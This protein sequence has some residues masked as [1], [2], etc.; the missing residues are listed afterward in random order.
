MLEPYIGVQSQVNRESRK[1]LTMQPC[2]MPVLRVKVEEERLSSLTEWGLFVRMSRVQLQSVVLISSWLSFEIS[3]ECIKMLT[4]ELKS[5]NNI[6]T[7]GLGLCRWVRTEWNA[8]EMA[9]YVDLLV[10]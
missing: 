5:I 3:L 6:L 9:S 7:Q 2:G 1:G 8:V 4:A 10:C